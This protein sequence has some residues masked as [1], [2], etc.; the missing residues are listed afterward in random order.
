[1][2]PETLLPASAHPVLP[3]LVARLFGWKVYHPPDELE[4]P[5][6][7]VDT[8]REVFS[9]PHFNHAAGPI[10]PYTTLADKLQALQEHLRKPVGLR[11]SAGDSA[12]SASK[13]VSLLRLDRHA[14]PELLLHGSLARKIRAA[15]SRGVTVEQQGSDGLKAFMAIY[16]RRLHQLGSA[17]LPLRFFDAL[18]QSYP[19]KALDAGV[20][21]HIARYR[22][23]CVG[24]AFSLGFGQWFENGWFAT[25]ISQPAL[26]V[27][28]ALHDAVIRD[29]LASGA[30]IYSFGRS[31]P[32]SGVHQ[33]KQQWGTSDLYIAQYSIPPKRHDWRNYPWLHN[34]WKKVPLPL[35]RP[36]NKII[37]KWMY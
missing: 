14:C 5:Y 8:G 23:R 31:S 22:G 29:A 18:M 17:N 33:F 35:A 6:G 1:M 4:L 36:F 13:V 21:L 27:A 7:F 37:A 9:L 30:T 10:V 34:I 3:H 16:E 12:I 25:D 20:M 15:H 24:A 28:Y 19:D 11:L 32:G 26:Y 2:M